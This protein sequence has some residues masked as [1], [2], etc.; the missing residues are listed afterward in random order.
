VRRAAELVLLIFME[1]TTKMVSEGIMHI[2]SFMMI[3]S[4]IQTTLK[5]CLNNL[6]R[7]SIGYT[8]GRDL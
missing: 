2:P 8:D 7:C 5:F 4:C 1:Y 3:D 6:R